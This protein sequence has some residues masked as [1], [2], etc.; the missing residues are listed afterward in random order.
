MTRIGFPKAIFLLASVVVADIQP[1]FNDQ[2]YLDQRYGPY[3]NQ[4][5]ISDLD[6]VAPIAN[7]LTPPQEGASAARHVLWTPFGP[8][9]GEPINAPSILDS[10][11]LSLVYQGPIYDDKPTAT[12]V[13]TCNGTDYLTWWSG[14]ERGG[15]RVGNYY[16]VCDEIM[17]CLLMLTFFS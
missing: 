8:E 7:I 12:S 1:Y 4:T 17:F 13:Q 6:V 5:F 2:G 15:P 9:L 10:Q 16:M 3:P 11:T 14:R